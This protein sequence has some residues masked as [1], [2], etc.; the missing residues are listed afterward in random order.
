VCLE[1]TRAGIYVRD[2]DHIRILGNRAYSQPYGVLA[3]GSSD[4]LMV[5]DND[6]RGNTSAALSLVGANRIVSDN[7]E[8]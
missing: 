6:L 3:Q 2:S 8:T 7:W 1:Q 5:K 4:Y